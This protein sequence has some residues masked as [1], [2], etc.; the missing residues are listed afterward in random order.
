VVRMVCQGKFVRES[1]YPSI[2]GVLDSYSFSSLISRKSLAYGFSI[3]H[4]RHGVDVAR[5]SG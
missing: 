4:Q 1:V 5:R 2:H 3:S